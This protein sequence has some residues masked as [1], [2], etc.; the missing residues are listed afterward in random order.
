MKNMRAMRA[1]ALVAGVLLMLS[2]SVP[3][4]AAGGVVELAIGPGDG[5]IGG[6]FSSD[7]GGASWGASLDC[8]TAYA[9]L[10]PGVADTEWRF[11]VE[12]P[13]AELPDGATIEFVELYLRD[14]LGAQSPGSEQVAIYTY[15]GD[16]SV[17]AADV[18]V[19]GA[20]YLSAFVAPDEEVLFADSLPAPVLAAG[21]AGFSVRLDPLV[22]TS[23][24]WACPGSPST[25]LAP[26]LLIGYSMPAASQ[27]PD[28]AMAAAVESDL[29]VILGSGLLL[30]AGL[31]AVA[32][33]R[34]RS[35]VG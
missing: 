17:A 19:S 29:P 12:F 32:M 1:P 34:A 23:T 8:E 25:D 6:G 35:A 9:E 18:Q 5:E 27:V 21:W 4:V 10:S 11:A 26:M 33:I 28:A 15:P 13:L 3:R 20:P 24:T 2:L 31:M 16:G 7:D 30:I 14:R 22:V